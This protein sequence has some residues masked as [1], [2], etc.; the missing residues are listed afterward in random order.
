MGGQVDAK[1]NVATILEVR[2]CWAHGDVRHFYL[3]PVTAGSPSTPT[4][5]PRC[6]HKLHCMVLT[7]APMARTSKLS[8]VLDVWIF[9]GDFDD[10]DFDV[11]LFQTK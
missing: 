6:R 10:L 2:V 4:T 11:S 9:V 7:F 3:N 1:G 8:V 5:Q